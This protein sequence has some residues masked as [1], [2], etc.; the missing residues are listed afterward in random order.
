MIFRRGP[1][2][3]LFLAINL[4]VLSVCSYIWLIDP[5][6]WAQMIGGVFAIWA[7][8]VLVSAIRIRNLGELREDGLTLR[9]PF[10][11]ADMTWDELQWASLGPDKRIGVIGYRKTGEQKDRFVGV[12]YK[13]LQ[14]EAL[15]AI[16]GAV[17]KARPDLP[18]EPPQTIQT[19]GAT[20]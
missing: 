5:A 14:P 20:S 7:A 18:T 10:G 3:Y 9:R 12:S 2:Q 8:F 6:R 4:V 15:A 1:K 16:R 11:T 17:Q 19:N 13:H